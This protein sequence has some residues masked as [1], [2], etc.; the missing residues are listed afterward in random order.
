MLNRR[1]IGRKRSLSVLRKDGLK[2]TWRMQEFRLP[3]DASHMTV[4]PLITGKMFSDVI[5]KLP[6]CAIL[7]ILLSHYLY[8]LGSRRA[9]PVLE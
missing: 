1:E 2:T 5:D 8:M 9:P 3:E 6:F 7:Y 4:S